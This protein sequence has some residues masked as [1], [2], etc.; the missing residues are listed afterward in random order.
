MSSIARRPWG[1][2]LVFIG[3]AVLYYLVFTVYP[4]V[5]TV[6]NSFHTIEPVEGRLAARFVGLK[7]YASLVTD[8]IF[9]KSVGNTLLWATVGPALEM[10]LATSLAFIVFFKVPFSNFYR[11]VWFS[12]MLVSGVIVGLVFRWFFNYDWGILNTLLRALGLGKLAVNWLG[13]LQAPR[14]IVVFVHLWNTFGYSFILLLS[15]LSTVP[16]E[17]IES[18]RLDGAG[19]WAIGRRILFPLLLPTF[20]TVLMLS[21]MGKMRGFHIVWALTGG[22]PLHASETVATYIQKRAFQWGTLDMGYPSAIA[23]LWFLVVLIGIRLISRRARK[24]MEAL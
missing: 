19:N 24:G 12:P 13:T 15:G 4:V 14:W 16:E 20:M 9:R 2:I 18:A 1:W 10:A 17:V 21:F 5:A 8:E 11:I 22:G 6:V 3:P 23:T 7:N